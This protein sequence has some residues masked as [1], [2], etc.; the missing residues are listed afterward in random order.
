MAISVF[1]VF[2]KLFSLHNSKNHY[3]ND[4]FKRIIDEKHGIGAS[5]YIVGAFS[6]YLTNNN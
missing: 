3:S 6:F 2:F 5:D 1:I 4:Y